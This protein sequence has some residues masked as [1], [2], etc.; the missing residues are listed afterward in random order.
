MERKKYKTKQKEIILDNIKKINHEFTIQ[1]LYLKLNKEVGLTTIYRLVDKLVS[2][3]VLN[4]YITSDNKT[5]YEYLKKCS[6]E[7]HF[8]LKCNNCSKLIHIDCDCIKEL[9][10]HILNNHKFNINHENI[11]INGICSKCRSDKK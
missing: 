7:N 11:V 5:Y 1:E 3:K 9:E 2:D 4:K 6:H 10:N 8:Y